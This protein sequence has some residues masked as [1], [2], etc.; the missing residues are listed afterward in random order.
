MKGS[1]MEIDTCTL[2]EV[3]HDLIRYVVI[4][5]AYKQEWIVIRNKHKTLWEIPG[6]KRESGETLL[7]AACRELYEE[8]GAV[9]FE[10]TPFSI[11]FMNGSYG[12]NFYAEI[13][14]LGDLPAYEIGEIRFC[15]SLPDGLSY[16]ALYYKMFDQWN[17][18]KDQADLKK[19][20]LRAGNG[21]RF[22]F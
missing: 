7:E 21:N 4:L 12:M 9:A 20:T 22:D 16:G 1:P 15:S 6:G 18:L 2:S 19:Y 17:E 3:N 14:E 5:A 10:L 11:Y 8:T 13:T